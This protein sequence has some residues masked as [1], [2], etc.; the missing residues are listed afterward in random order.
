MP[1]ITDLSNKLGV[2]RQTIYNQKKKGYTPALDDSGHIDIDKSIIAYVAHLSE[3]NRKSAASN[4]RY[5]SIS[6]DDGAIDWKVE[7]DKQSAIGKHLKNEKY[8]G[9]LI[10]AEAMIELYNAPLTFV[11]D[12]LLDLPNQIQKRMDLSHEQLGVL[13]DIVRGDLEALNGK[14]RYELQGLIESVIKRNAQY[15]SPT[16]EEQNNPVGDEES[17]S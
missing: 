17:E 7:N 1:T 8:R 2:T 10:P 6:E 13:D 5:S 9:E 12:K 16:D 11:K 15:Y 4:A 14:T 3:I